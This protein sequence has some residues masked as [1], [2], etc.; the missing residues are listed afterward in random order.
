MQMNTRKQIV[1]L[2]V[3]V[4]FFLL[5]SGWFY[6]QSA[7]HL[8]ALSQVKIMPNMPLSRF[9]YQLGP[10]QGTDQPISETVL[11]VAANDDYLSRVY[12]DTS[13]HLYA[14]LYVAYT[15]EPRRMLGHRPR[16]CYVGSGWT[17]GSTEEQVF[18]TAEGTKIPCLIHQFYKTGLDYR[19]IFVLN[20]YVVNGELTADHKQFSGLRWRRPKLTDG[21]ADYVAQVQISSVSEAAVKALARDLS[22]AVLLHFQMPPQP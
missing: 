6:R 20:F 19:G 5:C 11:K 16:V 12:S 18:E 1:L 21:L 22:D 10:W 9:P 2:A 15:A 8:N 17:H 7:I 14:S 13:R 4:I 3:T